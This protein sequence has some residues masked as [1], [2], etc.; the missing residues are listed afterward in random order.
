M[1]QTQQA[2]KAAQTRTAITPTREENFPEW[3]QSVVRAADMAENS[4]VRGSMVIK[5]Y[6][7]GLWEQIQRALDD[8][9][10]EEGVQNAYFPLLIPLSFI[11]REAE[12]VEGFAKECA[13]VTHHRLEKGPD[14]GLIPAP[15]AQLEEPFVIRP[16][17]ETIIGDSMAKWVQ[18]Y[19]DLPLLLNQW[20]NVMR[21]EMR[22]RLFLRTSEFL[23][24]EGHNAF[25][26]SEQAEADARKMLEVYR[27]LYTDF[28]AMSPFTGEKTADE[29]FP[30]AVHTYT[31][32]SMMQDGKSLQ[33][34]TSHNLGQNFAKSCGIKFQG[35]D[36]NEHFAHT[37]SWGL[38]TR[39]IG[40]LIM[41]HGDDDGLKMPPRIAPI[42]VMILPI[43]KNDDGAAVVI[44]YAQKIAAELKAI[45][46]RVSID[47]SENR[48]PD[49]MWSA[50]KKGIP[51]RV[52]VGGREVEEGKLTHTRRDL[53]RDSK[54]SCTVAEFIGSVKSILDDI[55]NAMFQ[56]NHNFSRSR[57]VECQT[58]AQMKEYFETTKE[59]G[60]AKVPVTLLD[61]EALTSYRKENALTTRCMPFEDE[62]RMVFIGKAY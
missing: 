50:I 62:G 8:K 24:Q 61:D 3:Y 6:G 35:R 40:G 52:E 29:R 51:L 13:V 59:L 34:A 15:D 16:T 44:E 45:G 54:T 4:P 42:Q 11:S 27:S 36:G 5:P 37:T 41:T 14:G 22:T 7:Y 30:G 9:I 53:G 26:T 47:L 55:H 56:S 33:A 1:S 32:E 10:K 31:I 20:C 46:V 2:A 49:K 19:R 23:W 60:F 43:T 28:F 57:I 39:S 48:A 58:A 12:H 17:S 18:S 21:W 38:S 25:E